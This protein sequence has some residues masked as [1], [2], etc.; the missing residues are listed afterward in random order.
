[1][2]DVSV[3]LAGEAWTSIQF[4]IKG[5]DFFSRSTYHESIEHLQQA[6]ETNGM[7]TDYIPTGKAAAEFP[8]S[9][10]EIAAYDVVVL[11]DIGYNTLALPPGT[12]DNFEQHPNRIRLL[13]EFVRAGG[14]L[15]MVGGYLSFTGFNGKA[16]YQGTPIEEA[17]PVTMQPY[18]D[19][20]ERS[21]GVVPEQTSVEHPVTEDVPT[22]WPALLGYNRVTPDD[23]ADELV[24]VDDD[25]LVVTG[26]H[27]DGRS[28][29]FTSDCAPHWG[30]PEY[31]AWDGYDPF[32]SNLIEWVAGGE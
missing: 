14:G 21:D 16:R 2:S 9:A 29:A 11:S 28:A 12:F 8:L 6:L 26:H 4:D 1:M 23:D 13:E 22:D 31:V 20:V 18:D 25:P 7:D 24:A 27:G 19:R 17:L 5:F 32:W 10:E 3:L 30:S 15:V